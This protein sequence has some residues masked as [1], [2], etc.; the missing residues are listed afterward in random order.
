M[1]VFKQNRYLS[2]I[3]ILLVILNLATL[4]MLWLDRPSALQKIR[5]GWNGF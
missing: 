4:T 5:I 2:I 3:I 1:D